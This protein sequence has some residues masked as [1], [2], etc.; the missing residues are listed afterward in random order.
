MSLGKSVDHTVHTWGEDL[1]NVTSSDVLHSIPVD[2]FL[3]L[4]IWIN[5]ITFERYE[6]D[7]TKTMLDVL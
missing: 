5:N 2:L 7:S 4:I 3:T 1:P 6:Y